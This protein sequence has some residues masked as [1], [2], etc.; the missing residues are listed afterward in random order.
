MGKWTQSEVRFLKENYPLYG[1]DYCAEALNRG[2]FGI[3]LKKGGMSL[4]QSQQIPERVYTV[5]A[6]LPRHCLLNAGIAHLVERRFTK[7]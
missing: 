4:V 5:S 3:K 2:V 1:T 7:A 6:F